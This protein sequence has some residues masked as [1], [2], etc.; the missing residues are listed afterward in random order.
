MPFDPSKPFEVLDGETAVAE[1][2]K[3]DSSKP[4]EKVSAQTF[5]P[6]Q[7]FEKVEADETKHDAATPEFKP[8]SITEER[9]SRFL[10]LLEAQNQFVKSND[11][12]SKLGAEVEQSHNDLSMFDVIPQ[13]VAA[14]HNAKLDSY[15]QL[16][17]TAKGQHERY[18]A[19]HAKFNERIDR[20]ESPLSKEE[21]D[22]AYKASQPPSA[23]GKIIASTGK[24]AGAIGGDV[25][26]APA[27]V[28]GYTKPFENISSGSDISEPLPVEK[29]I[30]EFSKE[31]PVVGTAAKVGI[32]LTKMAPLMATGGLPAWAQKAVAVGFSADMVWNA[33]NSKMGEVIGDELAKPPKER[34]YDRLTTA[35]EE[36][37]VTTAFAPL[38]GAH[39][40]AKPIEKIVR[41]KAYLINELI[42]EL[43]KEPAPTPQAAWGAPLANNLRA[44]NAPLTAA[45]IEK[46]ARE[47]VEVDPTLTPQTDAVLREKS[48][49]N[50]P[51]IVAPETAEKPTPAETITETEAKTDAKNVGPHP[52]EVAEE[53][54]LSQADSAR[55]WANIYGGVDN[56]LKESYASRAK[57]VEMGEIKKAQSYD[58]VIGGLEAIKRGEIPLEKA[59]EKL[60]DSK[61]VEIV[62]KPTAGAKEIQP[63][64]ATQEQ[65]VK[66][67]ASEN[68]AEQWKKIH[69]D[70]VKQAIAEGKK[71]PDEVLA[72]YP[73]LANKLTPYER[74]LFQGG[75]LMETEGNWRVVKGRNEKGETRFAIFDKES[76]EQKFI[77]EEF[78][79]VE[80]ARSAIK[81]HGKL[82]G[83]GKS[84]VPTETPA[85][86]TAKVAEHV[87]EVKATEGAQSAKEIKTEL[88]ERLE[89]AM[90]K[91]DGEGKV[92]IR[93]PGDGN[94]TIR[95][96]KDALA[97]VLKEAQRLNT[98]SGLR[99]PQKA[100]GRSGASSHKDKLDI[101]IRQAE[102]IYGDGRRAV[103]KLREQLTNKDLEID[104]A[105]RKIIEEAVD[106]MESNFPENIARANVERLSAAIA[107]L[108]GEIAKAETR[109]SGWE[110]LHEETVKKYEAA[111]AA[112]RGTQKLYSSGKRLERDIAG[113]KREIKS[114]QELLERYKKSLAE[115]ESVVAENTKPI[116]SKNQPHESRIETGR[117]RKPRSVFE[118]EEGDLLDLLEERFGD[119]G[120]GA[121]KGAFGRGG[122]YQFPSYDAFRDWMDAR[123]KE[124]DIEGM[125]LAFAEAE[126]DAKVRYIKENIKGEQH[127][128][129]WI[130]HLATGSELPKADPPIPRT[131]PRP[132]PSGRPAPPRAPGGSGSPPTG[133]RPGPP[134]EKREPSKH[135]KFDITALTQLFRQFSKSPLVNERLKRAYGR[136]T[137]GAKNVELKAR[138]MWD[139][140]LAERVLGHEIGHFIDLAVAEMGDGKQLALR[141]AP[142]WDQ[143]RKQIHTKTELLKE[144]RSLSRQWRGN[145]PPGHPY[146]DTAVELFADFM[147]AMFN[148]PQW[149]NVNYPK[150]YDKFQDL[151]EG[152]PQFAT[153]YREIETW[154]Q[155]GTM[156]QELRTQDTAAVKRTFDALLKPKEE[157]K[158]S[159]SDRLKF[160]TLSLWQRAFEKEG[161]PR[162]LGKSITDEL[163][164]SQ[165]WA[166]KENAIWADDFAKNVVP[167]LEKV[168]SDPIQARADL[169]TYSKSVRT[170]GERRAAGVWIENNPDAAR[171]MLQQIVRND[172]SL[173]S[174]FGNATRNAADHELYDLSASIFRE[175]HDRGETFANEI[176]KKISQMKLGVKGQ[177]ALMAFNVRGK[178]LNPQG[179][180]VKNAQKMLEHLKDQLGP[181]KYAA[182]ETAAKNLRDMLFEVLE[183]MYDEGLISKKTWEELIE[184]NRD[185]YLPYAVLDYFDG[186][187]GAGVM[188]QKGTAKDIADIA[189][190]TQLKVASSNS[191]RQKQRQ[192]QL[193]RDA[194]RKGG[195]SIPVGE[196]LER[197]RDIEDVRARHRGDDTS[198]EVYWFDGAPHVIEFPGDKGKLLEKA[199]K[200]KA[201]YEH[202]EWAHE[203]SDLTHRVMQ[204]YTQFSVP[205]LFWRNPIRGARTAALK[206]GFG[207]VAKQMTPDELAENYRLAQNYAEAA[208]GGRMLPEIRD[209]VDRQV[210]LPPRLSQAMVRDSESLRDLLANHT[211]LANQVRAMGEAKPTWWKGGE[212]GRQGVI[213][214]EK[215]FTGYEAF[216]KI[217]NYKA[218]LEAGLSRD[219]AT[220]IARRAGIPKPGV[221]GK[222]G[223]LMEVFFPWTRVHVQGT[224][225]TYDMLRDPNLSKGF[226]ARFA[227]TEAMPRVAKVAVGTGVVS[228]AIKWALSDDEDKD[229]GVM[230]E[231]FRRV[232]PYKMALD[233]TVPLYFYDPRSGKVHYLWEF[234][235]GS[236][237]PKH[238]EAVSLR[239]PASEE[240]R[241][242]GTLLYNSM[243]AAPGADDK[244]GK[245][246]ESFVTHM[247]NW[248]KNYAAPGVSPVIETGDNLIDMIALG[249]NPKDSYRNQPAANEQLFDAGG[250]ERAEAIAGYVLNQMGSVGELAGVMA[251]NFGLLDERALN[252]L[253]RRLPGDYKQ[254]NE[255]VP[256]LKTA[257]AHDN[258]AQ[259]RDEKIPQIEEDK[260]RAKARLLMSEDV[261]GLYDY[262]Y[263]NLKRQDKLTDSEKYQFDAAANFVNK[264]WG[265]LTNT[266]SYYAKS[267]H[268]VGPDG[269]REAKETLKRDLNSAAAHNIAVFK[270]YR[271]QP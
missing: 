231:F 162:E 69:E 165:T 147:S 255:K 54:K 152:K 16:L 19:A 208:F 1:P 79:K 55:N 243:I 21:F 25:S 15:N 203:A 171:Y 266:N 136:F 59:T 52:M 209:L 32:G 57:L 131:T 77:T 170:I 176:A 234:K 130:S 230:A 40:A 177:D 193:I 263:R 160:A 186:H 103:A 66:R 167:E 224:R 70:I 221:G 205:F 182:L 214:S 154:L 45:A 94:F 139:T 227:L 166:A 26:N 56:A 236:A 37:L 164:Y 83:A 3:F 179:L 126:R 267:A 211:I 128:K 132:T 187:V 173:N 244:M 36:A 180:T 105:D 217:Y 34:D 93:I 145:F 228:G 98:S 91:A 194:Y 148:D 235:K 96:T 185:N 75:K 7:P 114:R 97:K 60:I 61:G 213:L 92:T 264:I 111:Q 144:A 146:R 13:E 87:D 118:M 78:K 262:Y 99:D 104:A 43:K 158:A 161:K 42:G 108:S 268:A 100:G 137:H 109:V 220:A 6:S 151:R 101:I 113:S 14:A 184:P 140:K 142:L 256:F 250:T 141:I 188:T 232:S 85:E 159:V 246:G 18:K 31:H 51:E 178:L 30:G 190:A 9:R 240:G 258:Y 210:L 195:I 20:L 150:L 58:K 64:E 233:D 229:D 201:F 120:A 199:M 62:R 84:T 242:W 133:A 90:T 67:Y 163:E 155:G 216:E 23:I 5:D 81:L 29:N 149:V 252:A 183:K 261:R 135:R 47:G 254:W 260:L 257:I 119:T 223:T 4:F 269:S 124:R 12:L 248:M 24:F 245:P 204:F 200:S 127:K 174:K 134:P 35:F 50:E 122:D 63:W 49:G 68:N 95:N 239:I 125:K 74:A 44:N 259:Y 11:A 192:V 237:V 22:R 207:N 46:V 72:D 138:L 172:P 196:K 222:W 143:M 265:D 249:R 238:F 247:G 71:V 102:Q 112:G 212:L 82:S 76:G 33:Y 107:E 197:S 38:A 88:I 10:E 110:K 117:A 53:G 169:L 181:R 218:A 17:E 219:Q 129:D 225:A 175:I 191:W 89:K 168:S 86:A 270:E 27:A 251:A 48:R 241:L 65:Y 226:A 39:G 189:A 8:K 80:H 106:V 253:S 215:V 73:N 271:A 198:R 123:Y 153:A 116:E 115:A 206:T 157:T 156:S 2:P 121:T 28:A 202:I 41:P